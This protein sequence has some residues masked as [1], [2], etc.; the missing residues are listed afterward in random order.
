MDNSV[1][2]GGV[3]RSGG[4]GSGGEIARTLYLG[5]CSMG[6]RSWLP[7]LCRVLLF[8][9]LLR[10]KSWEAAREELRPCWVRGLLEPPL[11]QSWSLSARG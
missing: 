6:I 8:L 3:A 2:V 5:A 4:P 9:L 1:W 11:S 10:V 7:L